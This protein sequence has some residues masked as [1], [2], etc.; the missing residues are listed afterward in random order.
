MGAENGKA[1]WVGVGW[2]VCVVQSVSFYPK[3]DIPPAPV[4]RRRFP[5]GHFHR[6]D[7]SPFC[8]LTA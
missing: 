5:L 2:T 3:E 1:S 6:P 8:F 7:V 4:N